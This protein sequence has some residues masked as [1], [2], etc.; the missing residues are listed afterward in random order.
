MSDFWK[1]IEIGQSQF[2]KN[3]SDFWGH[4][5]SVKLHL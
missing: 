1:F 5:M 4:R 2:K 3:S